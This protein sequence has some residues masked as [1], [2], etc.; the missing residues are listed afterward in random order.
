MYW[1][2]NST[3]E[4]VVLIAYHQVVLPANEGKPPA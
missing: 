4:V 1:N 3:L 2:Y